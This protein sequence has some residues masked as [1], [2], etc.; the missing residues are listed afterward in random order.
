[1]RALIWS[2]ATGGCLWVS[3]LHGIGLAQSGNTVM[4]AANPTAAVAR[5]VRMEPEESGLRLVGTVAAAV[6]SPNAWMTFRA[7]ALAAEGKILSAQSLGAADRR[8]LVR[9][10]FC[11]DGLRYG[12]A[13][14]VLFS[15][16]PRGNVVLAADDAFPTGVTFVG[17]RGELGDTQNFA[18]FTVVASKVRDLIR[19]AKSGIGLRVRYVRARNIAGNMGNYD[20]KEWSLKPQD[21]QRLW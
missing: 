7:S 10:F 3:V 12:I 14:A 13:N 2:A 4:G 11:Y 16:Q 1:M 18:A 19:T 5:G 21:L 20:E 15:R 17:C 6:Y 8:D 9:V